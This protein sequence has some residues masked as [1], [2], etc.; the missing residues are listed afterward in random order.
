MSPLQEEDLRNRSSEALN[1]MKLS[2]EGRVRE[3][4]GEVEARHKVRRRGGR[5]GVHGERAASSACC[6]SQA[7]RAACTQHLPR[8]LPQLSGTSLIAPT[9]PPLPPTQPPHTPPTHHH[10]THHDHLP[11]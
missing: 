2:L 8:L 3:L 10:H 7:R 6:C 4:E 9:T 5:A 11:P 1:V